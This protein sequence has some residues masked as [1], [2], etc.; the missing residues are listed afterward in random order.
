M[1]EPYR[2]VDV[3]ALAA[4]ALRARPELGGVRLVCVD[5]PA[6]SGKT[7][8]AAALVAQLAPL[9]GRVPVVHGDELYE[10]WD[11][12]LGAP[13]RVTAF[14]LLADR[15]QA[16]LLEPWREGGP[17]AYP[18]WDW[19][20]AAWAEVRTV[21]P[22][23]VVVLEGVGLGSRTLRAQASVAVWVDSDP[24][25]RLE[26]VLARDG[27]ALREHLVG[28][29]RDEQQWFALDATCAGCDVRL[30]T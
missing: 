9:V 14:A 26:R 3:A 27:E 4:R 17:A 25:G 16:Q 24:A 29:Q 8:V 30:G 11:V 28:W 2:D 15:V 1:A 7:T 10:G 6:G 12:V 18:V 13:D 23:A 21:E 5:G 19:H 22:A 20:A